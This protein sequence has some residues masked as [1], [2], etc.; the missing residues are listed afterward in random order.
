MST[1]SRGGRR[2]RKSKL[3]S[4]SYTELKNEMIRRQEQVQSLLTTRERLSAELRDLEALIESAGGGDL[5]TTTYTTTMRR[6]GPGR[7]PGSGKKRTTLIGAAPRHGRRGGR[8]GNA[9]S[10]VETLQSV[11]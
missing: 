9:N 5:L 10:L 11:L 7:P 1:I 8:R 2:G 4:A 3:A 6:R